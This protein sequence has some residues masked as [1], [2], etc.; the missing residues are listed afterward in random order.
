MMYL[1]FG[2]FEG[3]CDEKGLAEILSILIKEGFTV[4][5]RGELFTGIIALQVCRPD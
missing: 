1:F 5:N 2:E 3:L 4:H